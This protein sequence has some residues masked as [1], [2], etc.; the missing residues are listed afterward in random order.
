MIYTL[1]NWSRIWT[2]SHHTFMRK[3]VRRRGWGLRAV[4]AR[5]LLGPWVSLPSWLPQIDNASLSFFA[6]PTHRLQPAPNPPQILSLEFLYLCLTT[7][8][9]TWFGIS[10]FYTILDQ[11]IQVTFNESE[12]MRQVRAGWARAR[13]SQRRVAAC[14]SCLHTRGSPAACG[15]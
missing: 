9:S 12:V 4:P 6:C 2:E 8:A 7:L 1:S 11:L 13:D 14:C 5:V 15:M 3:M 10:V